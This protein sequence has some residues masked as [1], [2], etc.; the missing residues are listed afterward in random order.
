MSDQT[1]TAQQF[2]GDAY[3][4]AKEPAKLETAFRQLGMAMR[5]ST[6]SIEDRALALA[7]KSEAEAFA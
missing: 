7:A 6:P 4:R 1:Q 2:Y 5:A 3:K